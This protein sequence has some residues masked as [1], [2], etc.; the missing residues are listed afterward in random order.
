[1]IAVTIVASANT[2]N[3]RVQTDPYGYPRFKPDIPGVMAGLGQQTICQCSYWAA[4]CS[5]S[6]FAL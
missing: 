2:I 4:L 3:T 6:F 5:L 1:M